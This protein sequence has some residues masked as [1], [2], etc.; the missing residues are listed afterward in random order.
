M[1]FYRL[2]WTRRFTGYWQSLTVSERGAFAEFSARTGVEFSGATLMVV[3][4][5][6]EWEKSSHL[7]RGIDYVVDGLIAEVADFWQ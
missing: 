3:Q 5:L 7:R 4:Q 6:W 2:N 1:H